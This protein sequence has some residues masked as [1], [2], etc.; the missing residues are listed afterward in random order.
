MI[1]G[2]GGG[3]VG[4]DS[5]SGGLGALQSLHSV[6]ADQSELEPETIESG[7]RCSQHYHR[8]ETKR[9]I[10]ISM[11]ESLFPLLKLPPQRNRTNKNQL[12][13]L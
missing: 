2:G 8:E 10:S 9:E 3:G 6:S 12:S 11:S 7:N 5:S 13:Q 1:V 4:G